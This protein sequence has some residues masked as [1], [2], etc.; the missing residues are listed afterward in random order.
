[1]SKKPASKHFQLPKPLTSKQSQLIQAILTKEMILTTGS[2]GTGKT[3]IPAAYAA[4][5][6]H[7]GAVESIIITRPTVPV[8][9]GQGFL[10]GDLSEKMAPWVIP[11]IQVLEKCL[12]KGEVE[13]MIKNDKLQVVPFDVIRGHTFKNAFVILDEAQNTTQTEIKAFVTRIGDG[14][15]TV[16]N[17]DISQSDLK[18][19]ES[20]GLSYLCYLLDDINNEDLAS[21]VAH[22]EFSVDD[23]VRGNLCKLWLKAFQ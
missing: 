14:S 4:W 13:C 5:M 11:L 12:S 23:C 17:G 22:I 1:M 8:G 16:I 2:A 20:S 7:T 3:Y 9:R 15:K 6:Y 10:P 18:N 21:K 19:N